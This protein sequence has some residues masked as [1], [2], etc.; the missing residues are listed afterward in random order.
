MKIFSL[1]NRFYYREF[2]DLRVYNRVFHKAYEC[3]YDRAYDFGY[4]IIFLLYES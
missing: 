4:K 3:L 2:H 1:S